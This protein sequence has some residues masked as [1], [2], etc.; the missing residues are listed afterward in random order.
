M[1]A[2]DF[3]SESGLRPASAFLIIAVV[4]LAVSANAVRI[5]ML[6]V[7]PA[8][9][10]VVH[11]PEPDFDIVDR[12]GKPLA[13]SVRRLDLVLSPRSAWRAHTPDFMA[14]KISE[15]LGGVCTPE[16]L[17]ESF[18]P[19]LDEHVYFI[20]AKALALTGEAAERV[21]ALLD[22][23]IFVDNEGE[24]P[25]PL[26]GVYVVAS[27]APDEYL[28]GWEPEYV[29]S[30]ACR[31]EQ[32]GG[33]FKDVSP[34]AWTNRLVLE[35]S[36]AI[37]GGDVEKDSESTMTRARMKAADQLW[38]LM[39]P[40]GHEVALRDVPLEYADGLLTML[41]KQGMKSYQ[42]E[43][44]PR[45]ARAWPP[46]DSVHGPD[47]L[48][49]LGRWGH[50]GK[51]R[52]EVLVEEALGYPRPIHDAGVL[53][54]NP[55]LR[56]L[57]QDFERAYRV[58]L[59]TLH[60]ISGI[61]RVIDRMLRDP[62][63]DFLE[64]RGAQYRFR[65]FHSARPRTSHRYFVEAAGPTEPPSVKTTLDLDLQYFVRARLDEI[66][67][68][69]QPAVA[70]AIVVDVE[71]GDILAVD[72]RSDYEVQAFLPTWH[73]F[74][75][76][77][78]FK[79]IVMATA[80]E[81]GV[82]TP[83]QSFDAHDGNWRIPNSIRTIHE[84]EGQ[85]WV[86]A[87]ATEGLAFSLNVVLT[88]IGLSVDDKTFRSKLEDLGYTERPNANLG[89]ERTGMIP[90][91]PWK[92][93]WTHASISFG[94]ELHVTLWQHAEALATVLRGGD[95]KSIRLVSEVEQ[96]GVAYAVPREEIKHDV[97][98]QDTCIRVR[99]MMFMG[100]RIGTGKTLFDERVLMGTKTGTSEKTPDELCLH[101]ELQ[102]NRDLRDKKVPDS[103]GC[104]GACRGEL[105]Q[106]QKGHRKCYTSSICAFGRLPE[107]ERE[108]MVL[109]VVDEPQG[110]NHYGSQIAGPAA[111]AILHEVL[112]LTRSGQ[113]PEE[114]A[115][116]PVEYTD[117][118]LNQEDHPWAE[119]VR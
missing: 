113:T 50:I 31:D 101:T 85:T 39:L 56:E 37:R 51:E 3:R 75:P 62:M 10:R 100:A 89:T 118:H 81:A 71:S 16:E 14:A 59:D 46:R 36:R 44:R 70:M 112:G 105:R 110:K 64:R 15:K 93:A 42:M 78:T 77:S 8:S 23:G 76:G 95:R 67:E 20:P 33:E 83:E 27:G 35:L 88:Q 12:T 47:S 58:T 52:A 34:I 1:R 41:E 108:V 7:E 80:L 115:Q 65:E 45:T 107:T 116:S 9:A 19:D 63:W 98:A 104:G 87:T 2:S 117:G 5:A 86:R 57:S 103:H 114:W 38:D 40:D 109:V 22:R 61:E 26:E 43:L 4:L 48:E 24:D 90:G 25:R 119:V 74:T 17:L 53:V 82:V 97:F 11:S 21:C 60:P 79:V 55:E 102:H 13:F 99:E 6:D 94:H 30:E 106:V 96:N 68:E 29:L 84:A 49:I 92:R 69:H 18:L 66:M 32:A 111:K 54:A 28:L 73:R 72:G 91:L